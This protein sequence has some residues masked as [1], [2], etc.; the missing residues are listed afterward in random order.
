[1][2]L[3]IGGSELL[4]PSIEPL[5]LHVLSLPEILGVLESD[6]PLVAYFGS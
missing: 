5:V 6:V 2:L 1:M 4:L 3:E